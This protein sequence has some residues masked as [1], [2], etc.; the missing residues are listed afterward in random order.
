MQVAI[1]CRTAQGAATF[2]SP[3]SEREAPIFFR[4]AFRKKAFTKSKRLLFE[5]ADRTNEWR[6][7]L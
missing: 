1:E 7:A 2:L 6:F 3:S 4:R 5:A